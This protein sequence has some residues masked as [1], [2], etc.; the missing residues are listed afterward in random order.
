MPHTTPS[1]IPVRWEWTSYRRTGWINRQGQR[2][3]TV[4]FQSIE[5]LKGYTRIMLHVWSR[6]PVLALRA[7]CKAEKSQ[8]ELLRYDWSAID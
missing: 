2:L 4:H 1:T 6:R 3:Y 5:G 7:L 8:E